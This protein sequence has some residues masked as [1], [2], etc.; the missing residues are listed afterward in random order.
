MRLCIYYNKSVTKND[1][2]PENHN[3]IIE[4]IDYLTKYLPKEIPIYDGN[5]IEEYLKLT[6]NLKKEEISGRKTI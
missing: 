1:F 2:H 4:A 6:F 3:R 5:D